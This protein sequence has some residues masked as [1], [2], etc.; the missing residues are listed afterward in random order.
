MVGKGAPY[1][2]SVFSPTGE[3]ALRLVGAATAERALESAGTTI[4]LEAGTEAVNRRELQ[5]IGERMD[6][7][8]L[9]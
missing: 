9:S 3:Q 7:G 8:E 5:V 2:V 6:A 4:A 1:E